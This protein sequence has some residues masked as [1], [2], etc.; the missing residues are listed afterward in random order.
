ML[1]ILGSIGIAIIVL[2]AFGGVVYFAKQRTGYYFWQSGP[3]DPPVT[4]T[5]KPTGTQPPK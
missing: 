2:A 1:H 5:G 4:N 3:S